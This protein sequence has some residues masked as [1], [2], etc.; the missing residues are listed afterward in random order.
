MSQELE[1]NSHSGEESPDPVLDGKVSD[2]DDDDGL[3]L[4]GDDDDEQPEAKPG[5]LDDSSNDAEDDE[6]EKAD[7]PEAKVTSHTKSVYDNGETLNVSLPIHPKSHIPQGKQDRWVVKLPDFLDINAEPFDPRPFEMNVKTH[8]DKNQ[9]L[10]DK[11]IAVNTVRWRYAKSE[12]GGI[13]K[14]TNSQIIQWEDGTY[15]LRVGSEIFDMF[16]T[17]TD[18]NYLVSEHNEE[19]LLMTES[20]LSKSVKLVPAS[21]QSTTHQKLAK[22]LSAKQKK[23]SYARSVVT[24]EDPEERQRRLESQENERY[25]L[26]RRRKQAEEEEDYD[27]YA[28]TTSRSRPSRA[29]HVYNAADEDDDDDDVAIG[30]TLASRRN[31]GYEDDG[32]IIDDEEE[33]AVENDSADEESENEGDDDE[34]D[35][36][37]AAERLNRLKRAGASKYT[38]E[39]EQAQSEPVKSEEADNATQ[40]DDAPRK[41]RRVILDDDEEEEE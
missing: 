31:N 20:T 16:T 5:Q 15:S 11:L 24:K 2:V 1:Q 29:S 8:E 35:D 4:F 17:N 7:K 41:K 22:A 39:G 9:E 40:N 34:D 18:D 19:G 37:E 26:E 6:Q 12:T 10:L 33:E 28:V 38:N 25:R 23:E 36:E 30:R 14:E 27:T 3:D 13:F 21:F 32:F